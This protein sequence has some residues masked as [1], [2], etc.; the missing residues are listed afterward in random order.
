MGYRPGWYVCCEEYESGPW[1]TKAAAEIEAR[2]YDRAGLCQ[3]EHHVLYRDKK[4]RPTA[5]HLAWRQD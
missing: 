4:S 5:R 1:E 3:H 2:C